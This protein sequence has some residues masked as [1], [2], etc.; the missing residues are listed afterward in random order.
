[1]MLEVQLQRYGTVV[2]AVDVGQY[3]RIGNA[4]AQSFAGDEVVDAPACILLTS[5]EPV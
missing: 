4:G 3:L 1:M 5:L 2:T